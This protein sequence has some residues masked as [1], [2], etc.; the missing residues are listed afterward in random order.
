M[1]FVKEPT[2]GHWAKVIDEKLDRADIYTKGGNVAE[3][4]TIYESF[5]EIGR[6][7]PWITLNAL[8]ALKA[9]ELST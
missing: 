1:N 4:P 3:T 9:A 6:A 2:N 7:N 8:R 5:G